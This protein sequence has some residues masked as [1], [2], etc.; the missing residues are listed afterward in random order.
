[1]MLYL[2]LAWR[3]IWRHRRRTLIVVLSIGFTMGL[4]MFYDGLI[5]GFEDAIYGNAIKVLGGNLQIHAIG[6]QDKAAQTPLLPLANDQAAVKAALA[7]PE[8]AAAARRINTGG[9]ASNFEGS[10]A[11][12]ITGIEPDKEAP[13]NLLAQHVAEGRFLA[14]SDQDVIFIGKGLAIAMN[15]KVGDRFTLAGK[16][17]HS[18][19]RQRTMT[20]GGIFDLGMPDLEKQ[21][22][23]ISLAE[24]QDLYGLSGQ[25]TEVAVTLKHIGGEL[26]VIDALKPALPDYELTSWQTNFPELESAINTKGASMAMFGFIMMVI[27]GIGILNLLLMAVFER[28]REIGLLGALGLKPGQISLLFILEGAM[29]GVLGAGIGAGL[30]LVMNLALGAVGLDFSAFTSMTTYMALVSGKIYPTLG[31]EKLGS[32][33]ILVLIVTVLAAFYPARQAALTEP[34]I[35][36]HYV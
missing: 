33:V 34:A 9:L 27:I 4:M 23:Y 18:Q 31:L 10:F 19:M 20:V 21:T 2:R 25:S 17:T 29:L 13:V 16:A 8:V 5:A 1:M 7:H 36:L 11:V 28:T 30:G 3:N 35:A 6:Y 32:H 22:V 15:V 24:A 26:A 14:V 12:A